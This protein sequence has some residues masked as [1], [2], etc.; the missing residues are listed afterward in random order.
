LADGEKIR[1]LIVDDIA[2]TRENLAKADRVRA[3]HGRSL[4]QPA[5]G[6]KPQHGQAASASRDPFMDINM[7]DMDG[8]TAHRDHLEHGARVAVI[9]M[10]V[11]GEQDYLRRSCSPARASSL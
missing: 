2:D 11:Q 10:S 3:R 6:R 9:I 4:A 7:P 8:I 1:I 5:A